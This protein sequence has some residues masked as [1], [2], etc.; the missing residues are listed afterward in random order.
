MTNTAALS[1]QTLFE[2]IPNIPFDWLRGR[3]W[4]SS[5]GRMI[6]SLTVADWGALP[7]EQPAV[8]ALAL[9]R[10]TAGR[11]EQYFLPL[12]ASSEVQPGVEVPPALT[13]D[14][15]GA[16]WYVHDAF[17]IV[18]FRRL[19]MELL[20]TGGEVLMQHGRVVFR[21]EEALRQSPPPLEEIKLVTA[22]QS[23]SS[24]IYDRQAIMKCFRRVVAGVNPDVEVSHF[25]TTRAGFRH[26]P[27]MLGN[28]AYIPENGVEHSLGLLQAFVPNEG[29]AWE[30]TLAALSQFLSAA[31]GREPVPDDVRIHETRRLTAKQLDEIKQLGMLTGQMHTALASD[32]DAPDF[33]PRPLLPEQVTTW[34]TAI[35]TESDAILD[36]LERRMDSLP[37]AQQASVAALLAARPRIERRAAQL[38]AL[39]NAGLVIT[40]Y[41]GD[42]HLGQLLVTA[43]GFLI[44][45]FEGE[46]LRSLAERRAHGSPIKDV[47]GMLRSLSYAANTALASAKREAAEAAHLAPWTEAW[48]QCARTA[49]LDGYISTTQGT[50]FVPKD[51]ALFHTAVAVFELEKALYELHYELNNRP[52]WLPI[53]LHGIQR[54]I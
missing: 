12:V 17:Q 29:D 52:D 28:I 34:Q 16:T 26:T 50:A 54:V 51:P 53:P 32:L 6:E 38:A 47:A 23:N 20:I 5:K 1:P 35:L 7:L 10:Y 31:Q 19:L 49:F 42:Y 27:A 39:G 33:A 13:V 3:R 15:N 44:L 46:P 21:P 4:F 30:H 2:A 37:P 22:E 25:L 41:H 18:D 8:L 9:V 40:R 11:D 45:D 36:E 43:Q 14:H 48:E 24:I